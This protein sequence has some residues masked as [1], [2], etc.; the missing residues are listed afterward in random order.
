VAGS[1][2]NSAEESEIMSADAQALI[3]TA[4][5][6]VPAQRIYDSVCADATLR[7]IR[8]FCQQH[9]KCQ[10]RCGLVSGWFM[11]STAKRD[12]NTKAIAKMR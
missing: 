10:R 6:A 5:Y 3:H 12:I 11:R 9:D 4:V 7:A 2:V 8:R 1:Y